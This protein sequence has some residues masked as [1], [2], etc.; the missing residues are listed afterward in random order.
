MS[1]LKKRAGNAAFDVQYLR[2]TACLQLMT[3]SEAKKSIVAKNDINGFLVSHE[4]F[5]FLYFILF[6]FCS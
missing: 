6:L 3:I 5:V 2:Q 4:Q 1:I